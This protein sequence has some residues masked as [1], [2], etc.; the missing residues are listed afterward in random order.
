MTPLVAV[1]G[2]ELNQTLVSLVVGSTTVVAA[3]FVTKDVLRKA[4]AGKISNRQ[5][6]VWGAVLFGFGTLF[7][8]LVSVGSVWLI[9]QVFS[10]FFL[11][12]AIHEA[13][14]KSRPF[15]IGLLGGASFWCR[16]PTILGIL[17]FA[18]LLISR[19]PSQN[20]TQKLRQSLKPLLLLAAGAAVFVA[21]DMAY[22][23]VRFGSL[24]DVA[25]WMIP[26][27]LEEPWFHLGLF[28]LAYIP[29]NLVPFL[30]G[31][32]TFDWTAPFMHAPIQGV[33]IWF[34][35]PAFVFALRSKLRDASHGPLGQL[36]SLLLCHLHQRLS[37]WGWGYRYAVNSIRFCLF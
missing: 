30:T 36:S 5:T 10:A 7:W 2:L 24:F 32:P 26:G 15:V 6:Y 1:F 11:L 35:T 23:F 12:L 19:A 9:A 25:Y 13:F 31:L 37:G 29:E 28:N 4:E 33:A 18:G 16:L 27:I 22:N 34:T 3:F 21:L 17:F 8:W 14:N 20:W